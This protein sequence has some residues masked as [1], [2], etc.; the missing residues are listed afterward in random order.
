MTDEI[1]DD[2]KKKK[3][4]FING[5]INGCPRNPENPFVRGKKNT[6]KLRKQCK[7][8]VAK[9][10]INGRQRIIEKTSKNKT[11]NQKQKA[12]DYSSK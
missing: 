9:Q 6:I 12:C 1:L 8:E 10:R 3:I 5:R 7:V 4:H 11:K 2:I